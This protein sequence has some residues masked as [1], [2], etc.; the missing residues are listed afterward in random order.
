[1]LSCSGKN[2]EKIIIAGVDFTQA[3]FDA[4]VEGEV[5]DHDIHVD[6]ETRP[7][8]GAAASAGTDGRDGEVY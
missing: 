5:K 6:D 3:P 4:Y 7:R 2:L 8:T 1:M